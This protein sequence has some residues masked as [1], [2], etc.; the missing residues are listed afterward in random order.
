MGRRIVVRKN[1][2]EVGYYKESHNGD[3]KVYGPKTNY[4]GKATSSGTFDANG[5]KISA[6]REPGLLL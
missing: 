2:K 1:S 5:R 6:S 4:L 3:L